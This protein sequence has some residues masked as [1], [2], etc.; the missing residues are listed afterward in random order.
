MN[1]DV[2]G[3]GAPPKQDRRRAASKIKTCFARRSARKSCHEALDVLT[4]SY[5]AHSTARSKLTR[6]LIKAL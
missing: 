3:T 6:R 1:I 4:L 2:D 5:P